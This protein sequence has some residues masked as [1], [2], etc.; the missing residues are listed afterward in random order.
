MAFTKPRAVL[1]FFNL[2]VGD[3]HELDVR[4]AWKLA[5][6]NNQQEGM[7]DL[8]EHIELLRQASQHS[9]SAADFD[10]KAQSRNTFI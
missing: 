6:S 3:W 1:K 4:T 9:K 10:E 5:E 7:G 8:N 2:L